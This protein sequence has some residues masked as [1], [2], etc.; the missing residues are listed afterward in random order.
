MG[1]SR[2]FLDELAWRNPNLVFA[3]ENGGRQ[4]L[5]ESSA[6]IVKANLWK[7]CKNKKKILRRQVAQPSQHSSY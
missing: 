5:I 2:W 6:E 1:G 3:K 4:E 7:V